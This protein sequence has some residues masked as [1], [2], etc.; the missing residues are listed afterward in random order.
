MEPQDEE[1]ASKDSL[2]TAALTQTLRVAAVVN[3]LRGHC[4]VESLAASE[5]AAEQ[6][7]SKAST[8]NERRLSDDHGRREATDKRLNH[9]VTLPGQVLNIG[10]EGLEAPSRRHTCYRRV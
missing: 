7:T 10:G 1:R 9:P 8:R 3:S 5:T 4:E 6:G 2:S